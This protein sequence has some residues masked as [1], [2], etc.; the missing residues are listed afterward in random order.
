[1]HVENRGW[2]EQSF[3]CC[4]VVYASE[5]GGPD[6][7]GH[8]SC[9]LGCILYIE[10][11]VSVTELQKRKSQGQHTKVVGVVIAVHDTQNNPCVDAI[12][13]R[14]IIY[15]FGTRESDEE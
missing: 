14:A 15:I 12:S 3:A 10:Y 7:R 1:M 4:Q 8:K 6:K 5:R 13:T 2:A 9:L 11:S